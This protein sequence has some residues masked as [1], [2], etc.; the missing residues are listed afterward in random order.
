MRD[1]VCFYL[2]IQKTKYFKDDKHLT[3]HSF[4][5]ESPPLFPIPIQSILFFSIPLMTSW[6]VKHFKIGFINTRNFLTEN[7]GFIKEHNPR[8]V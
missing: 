3:L 8:V 6:P 7:N 2:K 1:T 5:R 4:W